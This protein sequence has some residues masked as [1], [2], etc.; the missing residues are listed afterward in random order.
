[1][2]Y[3]FET[4]F[5]ALDLLNSAKQSIFACGCYGDALKR[6]SKTAKSDY[7]VPHVCLSYLQF[8]CSSVCLSFR[9]A[10]HPD[11]KKK[12]ASSGRIFLKVDIWGFF[13]NM[14]KKIKF[15]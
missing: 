1:L 4:L 6:V 13:E 10:I 3:P 2:E 12:L 11:G 15:P 14:S 5:G 7:L 8:V 9:P